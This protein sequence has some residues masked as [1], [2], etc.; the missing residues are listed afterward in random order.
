MS[1]AERLEYMRKHHEAEQELLANGGER[2]PHC[3]VVW[4]DQLA[5]LC[6]PCLEM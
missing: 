5:V 2:C 4:E 6:C 3:L 1:E